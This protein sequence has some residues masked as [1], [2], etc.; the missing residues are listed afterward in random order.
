VIDPS[1]PASNLVG[2]L[3]DAGITV[4]LM[5]SAE[6][7]PAFSDMYDAMVPPPDDPTWRPQYLHTGGSLLVAHFA[8]AR[9]A[10]ATAP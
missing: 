9:S 6:L 4:H 3:E 8:E 2:P 7:A 10:P 5:K 1:S